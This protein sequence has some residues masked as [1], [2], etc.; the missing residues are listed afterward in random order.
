MAHSD[1]LAM[2]LSFHDL[3]IEALRVL[4]FGAV[5]LSSALVYAVVS[6][7][8]VGT[9]SLSLIPGTSVAYVAS[10]LVSYFGHIHV[11]FRVEPNHRLMLL[12]FIALGMVSFVI[13]LGATW[14]FD[15]V[16]G[17]PHYV[18]ILVVIVL[19]PA[20]NYVASRF[21]VFL[22]AVSPPPAVD[23]DSGSP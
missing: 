17:A 16:L 3:A 14:C 23:R 1:D 15:R 12:R 5:G 6:G 10:F 8:L 2:H 18:S 7:F 13:T 11:S 22:P 4:R 20:I 21:W 19:I 9:G